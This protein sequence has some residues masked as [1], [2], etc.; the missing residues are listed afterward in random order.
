[1]PGWGAIIQKKVNHGE[2]QDRPETAIADPAHQEADR[3]FWRF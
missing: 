1:M 2:A 3:E